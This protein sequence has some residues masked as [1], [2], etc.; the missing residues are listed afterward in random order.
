MGIRYRSSHKIRF[1]TDSALGGDEDMDMA[2]L[3]RCGR[4]KDPSTAMHYQR[5]A[6]EKTVKRRAFNRQFG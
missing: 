5:M 1:Y 3:M 2:T 6:R 4:W